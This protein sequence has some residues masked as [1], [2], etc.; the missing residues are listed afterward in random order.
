M[1]EIDVRGMRDVQRLFSGLAQEQIPY[2]QMIAI[3]EVAFK[4]KRAEQDEMQRVFS[5]PIHPWILRQIAVRKASK[6]TLTA[7]IGTPEGLRDIRGNPS[8]FARTSSGVF[9]RIL[10]P[11]IEGGS[12]QAKAGERRLRTA[13]ILPNGWFALPGKG[14]TLDQYGNL[15][16]QWW[17]MILS[18]LNAAQWSRQGAMQNRA[19]RVRNRRNRLERQGYDLFAVS[20]AHASRLYPGVYLRKGGQIKPILIFV[21]SVSYQRRLDWFGVFDRTVRAEL[22][23]AAANAVQRAIDTAR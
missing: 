1:I 15:S 19:E 22:P 16:G 13:G 20:P 14:A 3:N 17:M 11:H 6:Q 8:G 12:R 9:E 10:S 7:V 2:A 18:W 5:S 23:G 4:V 21:S